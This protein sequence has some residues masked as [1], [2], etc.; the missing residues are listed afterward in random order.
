MAGFVESGIELDFPT[1]SWFRFEK[2]EPHKSVSCFSFKE[3][4]ACWIDNEHNRFYAIELKDY[5][6]TGSLELKNAA[7]RKW[8][9][10]KKVIDTM[11]MYLAAKY[12]NS[13]GQKLEREKS[14]DLHSTCLEA[15]FITIV[16]VADS[17]KGYMGAFKDDCMKTLRG[18]NKIWDNT[19]ITVM[20]YEQAKQKLSFVK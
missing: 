17:S 10:A 5:T 3:M 19:H 14:I 6:A 13:F 18:Y 7:D 2:S 11:Q 1:D 12:Q 15:F 8:N 16:N 4:D 9:I 20:T